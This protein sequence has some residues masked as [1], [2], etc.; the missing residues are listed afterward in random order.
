MSLYTLLIVLAII[1]GLLFA[2]N[3]F[4]P[5]TWVTPKWKKYVTWFVVIVTGIWL[6][7]ALGFLNI[8]KTTK[9]PHVA[10]TQIESVA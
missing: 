1:A 8:L 4:V 6:L 10:I 9:T 7:S 5:D 2:F 3:A